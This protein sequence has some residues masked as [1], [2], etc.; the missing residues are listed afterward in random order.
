MPAAILS[1]GTELTR[2]ELVST[3]AAWLGDRLTANGF[4][5]TNIEVIPD[6]RPII[7]ETLL[8]LAARHRV[9]VVTGGLGPTTDDLTAECAAEAAGVPLVRN[10]QALDGIRRRFQTL[11]REMTPSNLKQADLPEGSEMLPNPI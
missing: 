3:N 1:I 7:V 5:V 6:D 2:G 9:V 10:E 8:R 11:G 4:E